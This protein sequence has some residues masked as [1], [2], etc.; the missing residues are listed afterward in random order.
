VIGSEAYDRLAPH[1]RAYAARRSSYILAVDRYIHTHAARGARLL[2]VGSGDGVRAVEIGHAIAA[3][4]I[5]LCEPSSRMAACCRGQQVHAVWEAA[6]QALPDT[7]ERFEVITCLWNVL[8]HLP[9][10]QARIDAL[11]GMRRLL[12]PGGKIFCDVNNRHNARAYGHAKVTLRRLL[13]GL[14]PSERR[15]DTAFEWNIGGVRIPAS[16]HLFTPGEMRNL[17]GSAGLSIEER[18]AVDY[19]TGERSSAPWH[20]QLVYRLGVR[21]ASA[22]NAGQ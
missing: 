15:G 14:V 10:R 21:A 9:G 8:G 18:V 12:A 3:S 1:Y 6:A 7:D 11:S 22:Q 16:G 17:I 20:G 4:K 19:L 13:D 5:V 2:D